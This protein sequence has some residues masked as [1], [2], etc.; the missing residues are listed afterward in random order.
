MA[1]VSAW[2][3]VLELRDLLASVFYRG[4][5]SEGGSSLAVAV[6]LVASVADSHRRKLPYSPVDVVE[7]AQKCAYILHRRL[8]RA[9]VE[10]CLVILFVTLA[11]GEGEFLRTLFCLLVAHKELLAVF[12]KLLVGDFL[13]LREDSFDASLRDDERA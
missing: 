11:V 9:A 3:S 10:Y 4:V 7:I 13:A 2:C 12:K 6:V 1:K 8:N 5:K